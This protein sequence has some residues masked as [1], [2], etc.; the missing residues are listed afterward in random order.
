MAVIKD[1]SPEAKAFADFVRGP[2][3]REV[4]EANGFSVPTS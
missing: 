2:Q 1:A 3:G 4:L